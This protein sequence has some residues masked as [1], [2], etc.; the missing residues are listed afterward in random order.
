MYK[1]P[2]K[3]TLYTHPHLSFLLSSFFPSLSFLLSLTSTA[4]VSSCERV[5][6][7]FPLIH[8]NHFSL[9]SGL[10]RV[11]TGHPE[12]TVSLSD[13]QALLASFATPPPQPFAS[14]TMITN[15][16]INN[17]NNNNSHPPAQPV[18][19]VPAPFTHQPCDA[20]QV[21]ALFAPLLFRIPNAP[22]QHQLEMSLQP[23][24]QFLK[25]FML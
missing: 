23:L 25:M 19:P 9:L 1:L 4:D 14:F 3:F 8:R 17:N 7:Q 12:H 15:N 6:S 10:L 16:N 2:S 24:S 13:T 20:N 5:V 22:N 11:L 18:P 21:C